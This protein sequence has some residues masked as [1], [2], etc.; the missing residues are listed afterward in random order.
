MTK[1]NKEPSLDPAIKKYYS[2]GK[3]KDRLTAAHIEKERTLQILRKAM[4]PAP[5]V[6]L[7][8][9]GAYGVYSYPLAEN[10]YEVHLIDPIAVHIE[11]SHEYGQHFPKAK[12]ASASIGD[13]RKI[14]RANNSADVVLF[15]GPL[16]HLVEEKDRKLALRE[17]FRVLKSGGIIFASAISR[18]TSFMDNMYKSSIYSKLQ[19][20]EQD[21]QSG[22]HPSDNSKILLYFHRPQELKNE[23]ESCGFKNT[24]I[25]GIEGPMWHPGIID[26]LREDSK[27]WEELLSLIELLE[28]EESIIGASAHI[29]AIATK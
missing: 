9:G 8:V 13:A 18:F 4:P 10:G 17:A 1:S 11:Q 14:E 20:V 7:D 12:L 21:V 22:L 16:Y 26:T 25:L 29:M 27:N 5:A 6:I 2:L 28:T 23:I 15:F 3:E 19:V 24:S